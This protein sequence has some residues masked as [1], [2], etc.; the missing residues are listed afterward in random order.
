MIALA[1]LCGVLAAQLVAVW[2]KC[3]RLEREKAEAAAESFRVMRESVNRILSIKGVRPIAEPV[4]PMERP[5][6]P[7][8]F[9]AD[10][11]DHLRDMVRE[12]LEVAELRG[13][14]ITEGQARAEMW[15]SLGFSTAPV[16]I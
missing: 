1:I 2:R 15:G 13:Q 14:P 12:R 5:A 10:E 8:T 7:V 4:A 6:P 3:E 16:E 11:L 9:T